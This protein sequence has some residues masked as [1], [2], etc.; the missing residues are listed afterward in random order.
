V[1][2]AVAGTGVPVRMLAVRRMPRSGK[3][4][5]LLTYEEIS[6]TAIVNAVNDKVK[7]RAR[8]S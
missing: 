6:H 7:K 1:T 2:S 3:P 8:K 5:E 4:D